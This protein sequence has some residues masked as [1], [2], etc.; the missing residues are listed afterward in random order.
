MGS[1][2]GGRADLEDGVD[3]VVVDVGRSEE[4]DTRVAVVVVVAVDVG[5]AVGASAFEVGEEVGV[6]GGVLEGLELG[7]GVGIVVADVG[8]TEG[9]A[10]AELV[11]DIG[12]VVAGGDG[13]A[14]GVEGELASADGL[15]TAGLPD[16]ARGDLAGLGVREGPADDV[17]AEDVEEDEKV[18]IGPSGRPAQQ[19]TSHDQV[20]FGAVASSSGRL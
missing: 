10:D 9:A 11:E 8:A 6:V 7:L 13:A 17:A 18:V 15:F 14:I 5:A 4:C 20:W 2:E 16:E 19:V 3:A 1:V 12:D